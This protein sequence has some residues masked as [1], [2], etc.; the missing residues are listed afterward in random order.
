MAIASSRVQVPGK[1][2]SLPLDLWPEADRRA[3]TAACRPAERLKRGGAA[4]HL[5]PI[6]RDDLARRYGYFLDFLNRRGVLQMDGSAA[7]YVTPGNVEA[8]IAELKDRVGS[9]TVYGSIYKLRRAAQLIAPGHDVRWLAEIEKDLALVMRPRSKFDRMVLAEVLVE[10]GLTLIAEAEAATSRTS[11]SR[12]RQFRNGLMVALLG[13]CPI[14]LKN[15]AALEIGRS[16]AE[17]KG[18]WWI[19]LSASETKENRPDERPVHELLNP[20]IDRYLTHYRP[21]LLARA[22]NPSSALWLSSNDGAPMSYSGV[23][24]TIKTTSL[25][26]VGVDVSPH[27]FRTSG[28]S[29]AATHAHDNPHLGSALLHHTHS[30]VTNAS[31]NRATSTSAVDRLR[32]IV[33][34][35][36]MN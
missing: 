13:F 29:S 11:L 3:W 22:G 12:A 4:G 5:K 35:Y 27:L 10:A 16:F 34:K 15:F 32:Q 19:V 21:I 28:A 24:F 25:L 20:A 7:A 14:R 31:Y 1:V 6:T 8:Y 17:I 2:R 18:R 26:T 30:G 36:G 23:E 9:V 33:R